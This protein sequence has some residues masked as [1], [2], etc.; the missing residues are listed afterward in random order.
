MIDWLI[1]QA[2]G[3][4]QKHLLVV[5][6]KPKHVHHYGHVDIM[7]G[8]NTQT[9][10]FPSITDFLL[11]ID[12]TTYIPCS[13]LDMDDSAID[14]SGPPSPTP[15]TPAEWE[16]ASSK[17]RAGDEEGEDSSSDEPLTQEEIDDDAA[18]RIEYER[19]KSLVETS[20]RISSTTEP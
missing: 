15:Q 4:S 5:G 6:P 7:I 9:E 19:V 16:K 10:V 3:S 12:D 1:D 11:S 13:P 20:P 2:V 18:R 17:A 8:T 14:T